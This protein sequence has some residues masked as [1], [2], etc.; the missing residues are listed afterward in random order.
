MKKRTKN[1]YISSYKRKKRIMQLAK[2]KQGGK[3][4][5][6]ELLKA[7]WKRLPKA[8]IWVFQI[9][10]VCLLAFVLVYYFGQ[11]VSTVGDSMRPVLQNKD[12]VLVNRMVYNVSVPKRGD[13][14]VFKPKG[15]ENSHYYMKR[16]VGLPGE[17]VEIIENNVYINGKKLKE[18]YQVTDIDDVGIVHEKMQLSKEEYFVLGDNRKNSEDSR[19]ADV[20]N[21]KKEYIYGKAWMVISFTRQFGWIR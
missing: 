18:D 1:S 2:G 11:R 13:V 6:K 7:L 8:G 15:N 21:V 5:R 12:V 16:I 14:I 4:R 17:T 9:V 10:I 3:K 19:D 20:G